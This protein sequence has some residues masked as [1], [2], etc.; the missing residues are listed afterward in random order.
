M[1]GANNSIP[2]I[3]SLNI[4]TN[5]TC[6]LMQHSTGIKSNELWT[7]DASYST[8]EG[9]P[10]DSWNVDLSKLAGAR[11]NEIA[12]PFIVLP[13]TKTALNF[14]YGKRALPQDMVTFNELQEDYVYGIV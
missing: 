12:G 3:I 1:T 13:Y 8:S 4:M 10:I 2:T 7:M 11:M 14:S 6:R 9:A 5:E